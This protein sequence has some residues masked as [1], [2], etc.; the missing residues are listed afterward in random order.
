M[1]KN[2]Q[3]QALLLGLPE[4]AAMI[5]AGLGTVRKWS[6]GHGQPPAGF[7]KFL[8]LGGR[9]VVR[10]SDLEAWVES[11]GEEEKADTDRLQKRGRGRPRKVLVA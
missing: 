5:N 7:P 2:Q 9:V 11:L 1:E 6:S 10:R 3:I 8:K 4:V